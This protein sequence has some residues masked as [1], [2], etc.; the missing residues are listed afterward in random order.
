MPR[1]RMQIVCSWRCSLAEVEK[2]NL[3]RERRKKIDE[4]RSLR[5]QKEAL[6]TRREWLK[7]AQIAVNRYVRLRDKDKPCVSCGTTTAA[8]W[9]AGHYMSAGGHP[10]LRLNPLNIQKQCSVCN[11]HKSGNLVLF[12]R[13]LINRVGL[14]K[15]EWLEGPHPPAKWTIEELKQI[16]TEYTRMVRELEKKGE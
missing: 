1:N 10:A 11:A 2:S 12:R 5:A 16:K 15:V 4:S 13:E 6:K 8:Q 9:D 3:R 14:E 7:E